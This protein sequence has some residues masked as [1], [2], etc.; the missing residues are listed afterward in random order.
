MACR[1]PTPD[2]DLGLPW[3]Q[4][5]V[6]EAPTVAVE[7]LLTESGPVVCADPSVRAEAGPLFEPEL[8][9]DWTIQQPVGDPSTD[10]FPAGGVAVADFTGDGLLDY[11]LPADTPC[12]LFVGQ[13]DGTLLDESS[14]RIPLA[15]ENCRAWGA[16]AG[17]M[18]GD[19]DL[20]LYLPRER[21][22]DVLWENDGAGH[23]TDVTSRSGI[24]ETWCGGRSASWGDMDG[25]GDLDLFVARHRVILDE[26][27]GPC[28]R[29]EAPSDWSIDSGGPNSLL[30]NRGDGTFVDVTERLPFRGVYAFSFIGGWY[31]LDRDHD[32][33][34]FLINDFSPHATDTTAW[35]NDG[36]GGFRELLPGAGL[37]LRIF[38]MSLSA[39]D[40]NGDGYPDF[41][42]TDIDRLHLVESQGRLEW[43]DRA[44]ARGLQPS[45]ARSQAASWGVAME[46][47]NNDGRVDVTT[48]YG[49][50]EDPLAAG[51][52]DAIEQPDALFIQQN[53][54][55]FRDEG[56]EWGFD[57]VGVGR[58]LVVAD[59]DGNGWLDF[60]RPNYRS[61]PT[62]V[63][64]Q[65][66]GPEAW[67]TVA[68]DGPGH[69]Y[70]ARVE[71]EVD[72]RVQGRWM[73]PS[74]ESLGTTGPAQVHFGLGDAELLDV[75]RVIWP[76]GTITF[77]R[78]IEP[79]QHLVVGLP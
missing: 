32:L 13:D 27:E 45:R 56:A 17:D 60:V 39:A 41:A 35:I 73:D 76:D 16:A 66:C 3:L 75:V 43:A 63:T 24:P 58:G 8:G 53:D 25:D 54:G 79:R 15:A 40:L 33:D 11:F 1:G 7:G 44:T 38:G 69:G 72:G 71:I 14:A 10:P 46:D 62:Q 68:L 67:I 23:F 48:V 4:P 50:T 65:H 31:D 42:I 9:A 78:N 37:Q 2:P 21:F 70:G 57:D 18:D 64:Y 30:M 12:M 59:L 61:G 28:E 26:E 55:S 36:S 34:L 74:S 20:D 22:P 52:G 6:E 29:P 51:E 47:V 5:P 49:P 77:N 19:G